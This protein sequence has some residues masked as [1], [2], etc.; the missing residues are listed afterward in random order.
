VLPPLRAGEGW[1]GVTLFARSE[2]PPSLPLR[3]GGGAE[4]PAAANRPCTRTRNLRGSFAVLLPLQAWKGWVA[5]LP[6]LRAGEGW[7]GVTLFGKSER[8]PSLPLRAARGDDARAGVNPSCVHPD[9]L[10]LAAVKAHCAVTGD[11]G[12]ATASGVHLK[13]LIDQRDADAIEIGI[14]FVEQPQR[15][16]QQQQSG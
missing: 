4:A 8:A 1:G 9:V 12:R 3:A 15:G 2:P 13:Q 6:P 11:H 5:V 14:G 7:G 10:R 16:W